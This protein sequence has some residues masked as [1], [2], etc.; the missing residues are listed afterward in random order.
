MPNA[1]AP[2][3]NVLFACSAGAVQVSQASSRADA[4]EGELRLSFHWPYW[5][6]SGSLRVLG[7]TYRLLNN[8]ISIFTSLPLASL[9]KLAL[10]KRL[11]DIGRTRDATQ[12]A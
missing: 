9:D 12:P 1:F 8:R 4:G 7:G 10:Q 11:D 6:A 3:L 5:S 2:T